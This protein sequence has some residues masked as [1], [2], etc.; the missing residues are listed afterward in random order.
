M[1]RIYL[2]A[3]ILV[4]AACGSGLP[5]GEWHQ[6]EG[7]RWRAL[8]PPGRRGAGFL[9]LDSGT[10]GIRFVNTVSDSAALRNRHLMQ[11]SGVALGDVNGDGLPDIYLCRIEGPNALYLNLGGWRFRETAA[12]AGVALPGRASTGAVFADVDGDGDLDLLVAEMGGPNTLLLN[13][14]AGRFRDGTSGSGLLPES[15]GGT[16]LTLADVDGDGAP[17]LYVTNY[18]TRTMLDSLP[19]RERSFE[20][21]TRPTPAGVEVRPEFRDNYRLV[22]RP[23]LGRISLVQRADPDHFYRGDGRG[24][25]RFEP[26]ERN[27]RFR[28]ERGNLLDREPDEFGLAARFY[29]VNGDGAPDLYVANDFEDPDRFW[30]N[31]GRGNF[32]LISPEAVRRVANSN[33]AIDFADIDRDGAVDLFQ[34]D[35]LAHDHRRKTQLPT[36]TTFSKPVGDYSRTAQWQRNALLLN[37]GDGTFAEIAD[38]AG[39]A[40]SGWSWG[41]LFLDVDLDGYED[42]LIANGHTWDL[43]DGDAQE[44][45]RGSVTALDWRE[46]RRLYP[47]LAQTNVA[48]RNRGDRTFEDASVRWG[49][50]TGPD[51]SH[52]LAAADLDGDGDLDLVIN[53]LNAPAAILQ[54][55]GRS[56]R[57]AVRVRGAPPNTQGLGARVRV[58]GGPVPEQSREVTAGGLYLAGSDPELVFAAGAA[59]SLTLEVRFRSGRSTRITGAIPGRL[60]EI[61]EPAAS[62]DSAGP[63]PG[64]GPGTREGGIG[65]TLF[66]DVSPILGSRHAETYFNDFLRQPLL[67]HS[68]SQ[69]GPGVSWIDV[70]RDGRDDLVIPDGAGGELAWYRNEGARFV[71]VPLGFPARHLG[72]TMALDFPSGGSGT[73]AL[74]VA[75]STY[76][77]S[78]LAE[79]MTIPGVA[80]LRLST[81]GRRVMGGTP[82]AGPDSASIGAIAMADVGG[83]GR[84]D[85][86]VAGRVV[87]GHWPLSAPS[88]L[89]RNRGGGRFEEDREIA[90][91]LSGLGPVSAA[92][93]SDLD[94]NGWPD[95]VLAVDGGPLT[96][97]LNQ[98]GRFHDATEALGFSRHRGNWNGVASGD[99]DGDG[100]LDLV[101]TNWGRNLTYR[102]SQANPLFLYIGSFGARPTVDV[103]PAARDTLAGAVAPVGSFA[104]ISRALPGLRRRVSSYQAYATASIEQLLG[105]GAATARR[106]EL[107]TLDHTV[108]LNRGDRFEPRSLPDEAQFAPGFGVVVSDFDGDGRE[109]LFLAQNFSPTE[110]GT[111]RFDA[112]RG[113]VLL[114]DGR[115]GFAPMPGQYSGIAIYG[116]QRGAAAADFDSDGRVDLA[117]SQNAAETRLY[118]NRGAAPGLRVRLLGIAE[119]PHGIGALIRVRYADGLGPAREVAAGTGYWSQNG[120]VQVM[121]LRG[122]PTAVLVRWREAELQEVPVSGPGDVKVVRSDPR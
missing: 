44:R 50:G 75:R 110:L 74:V 18:K 80:G 66:E 11:G 40:A 118:R 24:G 113:L 68:L 29:D 10:T 3:A 105:A 32:R 13:D 78:S 54:N 34:V 23:E 26:Q 21:L 33:M 89:Y 25:F 119:N 48:Y 30:I 93:F 36:H 12:E 2:L 88:R 82:V 58:L 14:G 19:P 22:D 39:V 90:P 53:R 57:I 111:P 47:G 61:A 87:P 6:E 9:A 70:D 28:D 106:V 55:Q 7:Y 104:R 31:D 79:A 115:G 65:P 64:P 51:I 73:P 56:P 63:G 69:L 103:I 92:Q 15:R 97:L 59:D 112:G 98:A 38:Y 101:A 72:F 1:G 114:G 117:V 107:T 83:S 37:R 46:E 76:R 120:A 81:D 99:F 96:V 45:V 84:L 94:G 71:R 121:G 5:P 95:L 100:R 109:D 67:P 16:T 4:S 91:L 17:D 43:M 20:W 116:D 42:L 41:T 60:Y 35:M 8:A 85:L 108:W 122:V 62:P 102:A 52:A 86:F 27:P 49:F 77:V